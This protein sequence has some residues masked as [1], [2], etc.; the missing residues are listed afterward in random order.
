MISVIKICSERAIDWEK[1]MIENKRISDTIIRWFILSLYKT[2]FLFIVQIDRNF[3]LTLFN[4]NDWIV[5][6]HIKLF[7]SLCGF[8][9]K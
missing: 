9:G 1:T 3:N 5:S 2:P 4:G 6:G 8:E 7:F